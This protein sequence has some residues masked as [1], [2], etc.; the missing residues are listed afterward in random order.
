MIQTHFNFTWK[1]LSQ[2]RK[3]VVYEDIWLI[4]LSQ[5]QLL[6]KN[7]CK[8]SNFSWVK[9]VVFYKEQW[10]AKIVVRS[11]LF[12]FLIVCVSEE[13]GNF[14]SFNYSALKSFFCLFGYIFS[15][16]TT[17]CWP[18]PCRG[19]VFRISSQNLSLCLIILPIPVIYRK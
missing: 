11:L 15:T 3:C 12:Y 8:W 14:Q 16:S 5:E 7:I 18:H 2:F 13:N 17:P 1:I 19:I 9:M 4:F 10:Q 6:R